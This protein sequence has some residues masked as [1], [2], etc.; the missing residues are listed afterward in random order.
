VSAYVIDWLDHCDLGGSQAWTDVSKIDTKAP[1]IRTVGFIVK[2]TTEGLVVS[3]TLHEGECST[4][5]LILRSAIIRK[6]PIK[7]PPLRRKP[8]G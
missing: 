5:F 6:E 8:K 1:L 2:E 3:H 4:P 7:L